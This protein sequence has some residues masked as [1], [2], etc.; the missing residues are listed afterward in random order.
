MNFPVC[1][2][3]NNVVSHPR[4]LINIV[5]ISAVEAHHAARLVKREVHP[6]HCGCLHQDPP[7]HSA[8][9]HCH[10]LNQQ[11]LWFPKVSTIFGYFPGIKIHYPRLLFVPSDMISTMYTRCQSQ[12]LAAAC[13]CIA[14][15][16]TQIGTLGSREYC[17]LVDYIACRAFPR[18]IPKLSH[19][20]NSIQGWKECKTIHNCSTRE[21]KQN[22]TDRFCRCLF[23][24]IHE[25]QSWAV[26]PG[27]LTESEAITIMEIWV[28]CIDY[29]C[30]GNIDLIQW[31][32]M[33]DFHYDTKDD[34]TIDTISV[35]G[36]IY[37][38]TYA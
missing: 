2:C 33:S 23:S 16:N 10:D 13:A 34:S 18:C 37:T 26:P 27:I 35:H 3:K 1:S 22:I 24:S 12:R 8:S 7:V 17:P 25:A 29:I 9:L 5:G 20:T 6:L 11:T 38:C 36:T 15:D 30:Y 4:Q 28:S 21:N 19:A 14:D 31:L 32:Y